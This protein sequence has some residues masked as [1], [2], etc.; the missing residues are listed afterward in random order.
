MTITLHL[1]EQQL[2]LLNEHASKLSLTPEEL[3]QSFFL[4]H[5][6]QLE[7]LKTYETA[8]AEYENNPITYTHEEIL[9]KLGID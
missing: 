3:A 1:T 7:D 9:A 2:S 6:E 8:L 4:E 5:L